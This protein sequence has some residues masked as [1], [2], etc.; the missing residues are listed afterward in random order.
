M[1][2]GDQLLADRD[3][4]LGAGILGTHRHTP[5]LP[6]VGDFERRCV[7]L[8][9]GTLCTNSR[10]EGVRALP[11]RASPE[12]RSRIRARFSRGGS[13]RSVLLGPSQQRFVDS[14]WSVF[15]QRVADG[16]EREP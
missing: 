4:Q 10:S 2:E 5:T 12:I 14:R 7:A 3:H 9:D 15:A 13:A 8:L 16:S 1:A 11:H 6:P